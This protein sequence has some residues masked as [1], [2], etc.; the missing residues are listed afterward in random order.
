MK[1]SLLPSAAIMLL[2]A[3]VAAHA[4]DSNAMSGSKTQPAAKDNLSLSRVQER[5]AWRDLSRYPKQQTA[6]AS[7]A[8]SRSPTK[9][10][11]GPCRR[12]Q[13]ISFPR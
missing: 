10:P 2:A 13:P 4:A 5:T 11:F 12:K 1:L 6:S 9:S 3:G 8:P 7:F